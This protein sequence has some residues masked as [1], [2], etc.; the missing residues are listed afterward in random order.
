MSAAVPERALQLISLL[1]ASGELEVRL[2]EVPV[3]EPGANE[4]LVRV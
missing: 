1:H 4:V 2:D 3:P